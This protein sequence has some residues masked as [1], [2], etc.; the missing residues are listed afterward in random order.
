M[1]GIVLFLLKD[2]H[3]KFCHPGQVGHWNIESEHL[4]Q[5]SVKHQS[6]TNAA[7]APHLFGIYSLVLVEVM[8]YGGRESFCA[9]VEAQF[10]SNVYSSSSIDI[11]W[12]TVGS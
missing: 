10:D 12:E 2:S 8:N 1:L 4:K 5:S 7:V 3:T 6:V 9:V 11:G